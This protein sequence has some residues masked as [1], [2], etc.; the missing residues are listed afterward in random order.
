MEVLMT[1]LLKGYLWVLFSFCLTSTLSCSYQR[2]HFVFHYLPLFPA[3][4]QR[5]TDQGMKESDQNEQDNERKRGMAGYMG[6]EVPHQKGSS[7]IKT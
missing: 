3:H 6:G 7:R 1:M 4:H 2:V 5:P